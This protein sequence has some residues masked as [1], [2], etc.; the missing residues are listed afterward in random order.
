MIATSGYKIIIIII[1][2]SMVFLVLD[3]ILAI[4]AK[5]GLNMANYFKD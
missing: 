3:R 2:K 4:Q 5:T 1:I